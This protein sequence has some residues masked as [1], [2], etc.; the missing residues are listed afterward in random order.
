MTTPSTSQIQKLRRLSAAAA[1]VV[2]ATERYDDA[3][4]ACFNAGVTQA[5]VALELGIS[6]QAVHQQMR[7]SFR[8]QPMP[9]RK[10]QGRLFNEG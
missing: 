3:L 2:E 1:A 9:R 7:A 4:R 5:Q 10:A 6:R 8:R